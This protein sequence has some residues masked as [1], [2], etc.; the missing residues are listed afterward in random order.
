[1]STRRASQLAIAYSP[2]WKQQS[3]WD[4]PLS[5][6]DLT[7]AFPATS[8][9]YVTI[10]ET[11]EDIEDCTGQDLLFELL[12]GRSA[13]LNIDFDVDPDIFAGVAAF[14]YGVAA[15]PTGGSNEVQTETITATGGQ[16][17]LTVQTGADSQTT[18]LIN[19]NAAAADIQ[20]ALEALP[21]V[22][23]ADI[24][25]TQAG[26]VN[27]VQTETMTATGGTRK[28]TVTNPVTGVTRQ[29]AAIAF[30]ANAATIQAA[31]EL[32][33]NVDVNDIVVS[34][35]GPYVYTFSGPNY[36]NANI[37][38][39]TI[40]ATLLTGGSSSMAQTTPGAT[41]TRIYTF[42]GS[43]F[44]KQNV[45][46]IVPNTYHLSGGTSTFVE[47]T[48]GVGQTHG[49]TRLSGVALPLM[50]L[51]IGF[52]GSDKQPVIF[53]NVVVN[54]FRVR[55]TSRT[56]VT[57]AVELIGSGDLQDATGF[58]MP[59]CQDLLPIRFGDC[60]M[61]IAGTDYIGE[62]LGREFEYYFQ[63]DVAPKFDGSG[64]DSTRHER[65]DR[66]PSQFSFWILGEPGDS[67]DTLAKS[68]SS[69]PVSLQLGPD[70][71]YV[72]CTAPQALVKR[73]PDPIRFGG[74]PPESELAIIGRPRKVSGD[75]T[76]PSTIEAVIAQSATLLTVA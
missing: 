25:V 19:F 64:V 12:T 17:S 67:L 40:D 33:D 46:E 9:N 63:N 69:F 65:A 10:D 43:G 14:G 66:R 44:S 42:S 61:T 23:V 32:L 45:N 59:D 5:G 41:G 53:K 18:A 50:T 35:A 20:T 76:T 30:G 48:A 3:A 54:S 6:S 1:M 62:E 36:R 70:G 28:L 49:I 11:T 24:V 16:R 74:D 13:R 34:G 73:A 31:L 38:M 21:N 15:A 52:R 8:R 72:K 68:R 39:I 7:K 75:A 26:N 29:T 71:R 55:S 60:K 4:V 51:Y 27:E 37:A 56:R 57:C 22:G 58:T 47:T 2:T